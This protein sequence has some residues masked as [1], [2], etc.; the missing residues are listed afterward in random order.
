M[1]VIDIAPDRHLTHMSEYCLP[2]LRLAN[3]YF[4]AV[5]NRSKLAQA[6]GMLL[7]TELMVPGRLEYQIDGWRRLG[8]S[9]D[10]LAYL[11]EHTVVDAEH[12]EGWMEHVIVPLLREYPGAMDDIVFGAQRRLENAGAVCDW[13]HDHFRERTP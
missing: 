11:I 1:K 7:A 12:A 3:M 10:T 13:F 4:D 8:L 9:D 5:R 2:E 6:L